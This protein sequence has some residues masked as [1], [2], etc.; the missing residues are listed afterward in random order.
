V[1]RTLSS[2]SK[3][4]QW[5]LIWAAL[6][7]SALLPSLAGSAHYRLVE[8][9]SLVDDCLICDRPTLLFPLR[10]SF[11]LAPLESNPL[12]ASYLLT[13]VQF[14]SAAPGGT[15]YQIT[16][17]GSYRIGGE[18]AVQQTLSLA[19]DIDDGSTNTFCTFTNAPGP[20]PLPWPMIRASAVQTNGTLLHTYS[21]TLVTAP[22]Q[23]IWF[24]TRQGLTP[25]VPSFMPPRLS[26]GDVL[27]D[28][29][30][31]VRRNT[32]LMRRFGL[33]PSVDQATYDVDAL[34]V[35]PGGEI[36]FSLRDGV[37]SETLGWLQG[38][39][40]LSDTG[41]IVKSNQELLAA[42]VS[43][44]TRPDA[45]LDGVQM[46]SNG[47][48]LF[49]ISTNV[50]SETLGV[51]LSRGDLLSSTGQVVKT[52]QQ[53]LSAFQPNP[54]DGDYG[55]AAFHVWPSGEVWFTTETGFTSSL[56]P[57]LAG[58]LLSDQGY[59]VF[60]NLELVSAFAPVEDLDNFGLD[61]LFLVTDTLPPLPAPRLSS[62]S[63]SVSP[64]GFLFHWDSSGRIF[65]LQRASAVTGP[66]LP[67][68]PILPDLRWLEPDGSASGAAAFYRLR[69][70]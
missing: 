52:S 67:V 55:L 14:V 45:G 54:K 1:P 24:S 35:T 47:E 32:D 17:S 53:L 59:I 7:I 66:Y 41:R 64:P 60:H 33:M 69:S 19:L 29:G 37:F 62:P 42:F 25:S 68:S 11:E 15:H 6:P 61:A 63:H 18:V 70:W 36:L 3:I 38:G 4:G 20:N 39:D 65:Q 8:G 16:G 34:D 21:V 43:K 49:S 26:N 56:G 28:S 5:L 23:E 48:I 57:V 27:S 22:L 46:M 50:F 12:Y 30:R 40:L 10:G 2:R 9:S 13:N 31:V 44:S 51:N 58:D